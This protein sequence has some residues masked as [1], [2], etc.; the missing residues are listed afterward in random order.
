MDDDT[1]IDALLDGRL[2]LRQPARGHRAGTDALLLAALARGMPA[3]DVA[4]FGAGVG[5]AGLALALTAPERRL[6]LVELDHALAAL[7]GGNIARNH[8]EARARVAVADLT[9]AAMLHAAGLAERS[10]DLVIMNPPFLD[11]ARS[12]S[13]P[14]AQRTSSHAMPAG[15]LALWL[16]AARRCL[17]PGGHVAI[18]HR[19]DAVQEILAGLKPG[20]GGVAIRPVHPR[21]GEAAHRLLVTAKLNGK[22]PARILPGLVLHGEDGRFTPQAEAIHRR[23]A[24]L[25]ED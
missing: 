25:S 15:S 13:S 4:D 11:P 12:R 2:L 21:S 3:L 9:Q 24:A 6:V 16:K 7:A 22:A 20:F 10:V 19:A 1:T 8:L 5:T 18:I 14:L 17:R 23:L